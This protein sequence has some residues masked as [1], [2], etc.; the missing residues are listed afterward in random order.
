MDV[1]TIDKN[2]IIFLFPVQKIYKRPC[3][4]QPAPWNVCFRKKYSDAKL[5][6]NLSPTLQFQIIVPLHINFWSFCWIFKCQKSKRA[7]LT[8]DFYSFECLN[9]SNVTFGMSYTS[10]IDFNLGSQ[11]NQG[12]G[13][14]K[15][16]KS[17]DLCL[18]SIVFSFES[19]RFWCSILV[20]KMA[21]RF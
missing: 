6:I 9:H 10:Y 8:L 12:F 4:V 2:Y 3:Q 14:E 11:Y 7:R 19:G 17:A 15:G 13:R 5:V 18:R 1:K 20:I 21:I 16:E